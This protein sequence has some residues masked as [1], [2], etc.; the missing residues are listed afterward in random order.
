LKLFVVAPK[1]ETVLCPPPD[2][3]R[4][5]FRERAEQD[6]PIVRRHRIL[7]VI[8]KSNQPS[9]YGRQ[10]HVAGRIAQERGDSLAGGGLDVGSVAPV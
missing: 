9:L 8:V 3:T 1:N 4:T 7:H 10:P 2:V 6:P 5:I